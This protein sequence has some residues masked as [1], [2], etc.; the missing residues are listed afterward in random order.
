[1]LFQ[2]PYSTRKFS[3]NLSLCS[4]ARPAGLCV[5]FYS[6]L[7]RFYWILISSSHSSSVSSVL[8]SFRVSF[9]SF[10]FQWLNTHFFSFFLSFFLIQLNGSYIIV[11]YNSTRFRFHVYTFY[12]FYFYFHRSANVLPTRTRK[13]FKLVGVLNTEIAW[14]VP[15]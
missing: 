13:L 12:L 3:S 6:A 15:T 5:L 7:I 8:L 1:M 11:P 9:I 2:R 4:K 10:L 14:T